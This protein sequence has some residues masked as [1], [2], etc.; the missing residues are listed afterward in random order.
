MHQLSPMGPSLQLTETERDIHAFLGRNTGRRASNRQRLHGADRRPAAATMRHSSI[1][2]SISIVQVGIGWMAYRLFHLLSPDVQ[3]AFLASA[4]VRWTLISRSGL[5]SRAS[6][7]RIGVVLRLINAHVT[8]PIA[9]LAR[10]SESVANGD[11][12]MPFLPST[13]DNEVGRLSR[14][15][16]S[17][18]VALRRLATTMRVSARDATSAVSSDHGCI[19]EYGGSSATD[20]RHFKRTEPGIEGNGPDHSARS[21]PT[22]PSSKKSRARFEAAPRKASAANAAFEALPRKIAPGSMKAHEASRC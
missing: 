5:G 1:V 9:D 11:L 4:D 17:I 21:P 15:T 18:I 2:F 14:A 6:D 7:C 19:G 16:S 12:A 8:S 3:R 20:S 13:A 22:P 10:V